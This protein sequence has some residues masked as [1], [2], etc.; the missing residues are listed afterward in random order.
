MTKPRLAYAVYQARR[1]V[2]WEAK[3]TKEPEA[4]DR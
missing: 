2:T 4:Q 3:L 1:A